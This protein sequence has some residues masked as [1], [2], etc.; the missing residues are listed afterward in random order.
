MLKEI[1][2]KHKVQHFMLS[3]YSIKPPENSNKPPENSSKPPENSI[4]PQEIFPV[5]REG[6]SL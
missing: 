5:L 6:F 3:D 2:T 4:K 1:I